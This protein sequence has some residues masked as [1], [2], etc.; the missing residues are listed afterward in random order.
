MKTFS[1]LAGRYLDIMEG[2]LRPNTIRRYRTLYR[3]LDKHL[4]KQKVT[5]LNFSLL[6]DTKYEL[7]DYAPKTVHDLFT[8]LKQFLNWCVD[9]EVLKGVPKI[10]KTSRTTQRRKVLDKDT[11]HRV[12]QKAKYLYK[13]RPMVGFGLELLATYPKIRPNELRQVTEKDIKDGI[14][15]LRITK[16]TEGGTGV[17]LLPEHQLRLEEL[18]TGDP[19]RY[20]MSFPNGKQ[21]GRDYLS[22]AWSKCC[23]ELGVE[24]VPLYP[25]TKHTTVTDLLKRHPT[26]MVASAAGITVQVLESNYKNIG[27]EDVVHLYRESMPH[28][29]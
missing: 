24:G 10:P 28:E 27:E 21:F 15:R 20:L 11:Q 12:I 13:D 4:G 26:S 2:E 25:G 5:Q 18:K 1:N 8:F 29:S 19:D 6:E 17:R 22:L 16:N 7:S 3:I 23:R 9:R 14:L